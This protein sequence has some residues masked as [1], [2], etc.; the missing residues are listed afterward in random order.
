MKL[1]LVYLMKFSRKQ[2][3]HYLL[4]KLKKNELNSLTSEVNNTKR[5]DLITRINKV[6]LT[7]YKYSTVL[8]LCRLGFLIPLIH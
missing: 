8:A 3:L 7:N 6:H 4:L 5:Y 1:F 2:F